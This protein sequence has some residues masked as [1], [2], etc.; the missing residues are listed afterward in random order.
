[1]TLVILLPSRDTWDTFL[2]I[3]YKDTMGNTFSKIRRKTF[4]IDYQGTKRCTQS[5][6]LFSWETNCV[7]VPKWIDYDLMNWW[8]F[9]EL[10]M[11]NKLWF[12]ELIMIWWI[13]YDLVNWWWVFWIPPTSYCYAVIFPS[14]NICLIPPHTSPTT[15]IPPDTDWWNNNSQSVRKWKRTTTEHSLHKSPECFGFIINKFQTGIKVFSQAPYYSIFLCSVC[16][17]SIKCIC[18]GL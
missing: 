15:Y 8:W 5:G 12:N 10:I 16:Q 4:D 9:N 2:G 3:S 14:D 13:E 11:M 6:I 1:M 17:H 7:K 18:L